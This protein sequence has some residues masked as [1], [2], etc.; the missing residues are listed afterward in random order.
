ML[1][2]CGPGAVAYIEQC[3]SNKIRGTSGF[4]EWLVGI[5]PKVTEIAL[6]EIRNRSSMRLCQYRELDHCIG[7]HDQRKHLRMVPFQQ[8]G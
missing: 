3:F 2:Q 6:D 1:N 8:K 4:R 7:F 5:P